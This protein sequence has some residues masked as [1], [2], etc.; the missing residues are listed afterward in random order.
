MNRRTSLR[1]WQ[2]WIEPIRVYGNAADVR[3]KAR[4]AGVRIVIRVIRHRRYMIERT[5]ALIVGEEEH[6][7]FPRLAVHQ[8]I[9]EVRDLLLPDGDI[10]ARMFVCA[11]V[12]AGFNIR[13]L[14]QSSILHV[15]EILAQR[16]DMTRIYTDAVRA[17]AAVHVVLRISEVAEGCRRKP[18]CV[19]VCVVD[20]P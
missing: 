18:V 16:R 8:R 19:C 4:Q 1:W 7:V 14:R 15:G 2:A 20:L 12:I 5:A 17:V 11:V 3:R 9:N 6:R 10:R 13:K